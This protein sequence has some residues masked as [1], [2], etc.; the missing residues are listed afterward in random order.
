M[1]A[2][3]SKTAK[4]SSNGHSGAKKAP[5]NHKNPKSASGHTNAAH[6]STEK[7]SSS[8]IPDTPRTDPTL[9]DFGRLETSSRVL[10]PYEVRV[11]NRNQKN[12]EAGLHLQAHQLHHNWA[13]HPK[14]AHPAQY[15][16]QIIQRDQ[17][18]WYDR[19]FKGYAD[20]T[21]VSAARLRSE[22]NARYA[23][24][25]PHK[26]T[27]RESIESLIFTPL[28][29]A[30][31]LY[32][33]VFHTKHM[34]HE[35]HETYEGLKAGDKVILWLHGLQQTVGN[36]H[37]LAH[38][39]HE[40]GYKFI[41]LDYDVD[42][43]SPYELARAVNADAKA[44]FEKTGVKVDLM[45][46]STGANIVDLAVRLENRSAKS[47][48][49]R[50]HA[51]EGTR[52]A[53]EMNR[54]TVGLFKA[55]GSSTVTYDDPR[56]KKARELMRD[57]QEPTSVP[58]YHYMGTASMLKPEAGLGIKDPNIYYSGRD[59]THFGTSGQ[60]REFNSYL[61][62]HIGRSRKEEARALKC[63]T[64]GKVP[65]DPP[66]YS[67][68]LAYN[69]INYNA[70]PSSSSDHGHGHSAGHGKASHGHDAHAGHGAGTFV[71]TPSYL[72]PNSV[73]GYSTLSSH[74]A[75]AHADHG[76]G[77]SAG[78]GNTGHGHH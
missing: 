54:F 66:R 15:L 39:A 62:E 10:T 45:G 4:K 14:N 47:Y 8:V 58:V 37:V 25:H 68:M 34:R 3:T 41:A 26:P 23:K 30:R 72:G 51:I 40:K 69:G 78:H 64:S 31:N 43:T 49:E 28:Y 59:A 11:R 75:H 56:N 27:F 44:V 18:K 33:R 61:L 63:Y 55:L 22:S 60:G 9:G 2:K 7:P 1:S 6:G 38:Q 57:L 77:H 5:S 67:H 36:G 24:D 35:S 53:H 74:G 71:Y 20:E 21:S 13:K 50:V 17:K 65:R 76:H 42:R 19:S 70:I 52:N 73:G 32:D 46:H 16:E 48:V 12:L 29:M